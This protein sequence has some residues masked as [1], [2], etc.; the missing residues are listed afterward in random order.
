MTERRKTSYSVSKKLTLEMEGMRKILGISKSDFVAIAMAYL[1]VTLSP[2]KE[3]PRK[4]R[5]LLKVVHAEFQKLIEKSMERL[6][7]RA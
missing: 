3:T 7:Y 5:Q 4:R 6:G 1:L 2:L